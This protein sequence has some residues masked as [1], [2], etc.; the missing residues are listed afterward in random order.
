MMIFLQKILMNVM[1]LGVLALAGCQSET[2]N[3]GYILD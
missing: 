2:L 3:K 1:L